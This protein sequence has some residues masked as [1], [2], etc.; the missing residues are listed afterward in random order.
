MLDEKAAKALVVSVLEGAKKA[1]ADEAEVHLGG[2][3]S[4]LTRFANNE[5]HQNVASEVVEVSLRVAIGKR[6]ART[7]TTKIDA[8]GIAQ[9]VARTL[10]VAKL[11]P[12]DKDL[13]PVFESKEKDLSSEHMDEKTAAST[14]EERAAAVKKVLDAVEKAG[15]TAAGYLSADSGSV[16]DWGGLGTWV[17]GNST[18]LLRS[19]A[20]TRASFSM[21]VEGK[22]TSG[23][24]EAQDPA[25]GSLDVEAL[26]KTAIER[27]QA[28]ANPADVE[29]GAYD[30]ILEP[31]AVRELV[32]F[33]FWGGFT[34]RSYEEGDTWSAGLLGKKIFDEKITMRDDFS[35]PRN[36]GAPWDEEGVP[37]KKL[38]LVEKGV[39][40][41]LAWDRR[42]GAK[43]KKET[44]GHGGR[45]PN[46]GGGGPGHV[47]MEGGDSSVAAM[48][49]AT[50]RGI[51]VPH[52]WYCRLVDMK[53]VI[54]TGMTRDA[55][56]LVEDGKVTKGLRHMRFNQG[57][58]E[59]LNNVEAL[60]PVDPSYMVP[61]MKVR[62]FTFSSKTKF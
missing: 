59:M 6:T 19:F 1:G 50:K 35:D 49:K 14:P 46:L 34:G 20:R 10:E 51:L 8:A 27:C 52:F 28:S 2:G 32:D 37:R 43:F 42:S 4:A 61:A 44:T 45:Q 55:F 24:C 7:S 48:I 26:A 18:G 16:G 23:W 57:V 62:G 47:L 39:L 3:R 40:K 36:P 9:L 53:K 29:P 56:F 12:E 41:E 11:A 15:F 31:A 60:G 54:V 21:T 17:Y 13:L 22:D 58:I 30:V 38:A 25:I 33:L 5:I